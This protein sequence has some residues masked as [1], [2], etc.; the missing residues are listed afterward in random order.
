MR[1]IIT[2]LVVLS[3]AFGFAQNKEEILCQLIN[4]KTQEPVVFATVS[5]KDKSVGVIA[6]DNGNFRLPYKYK[7]NDD[8][9]VISCIGFNTIELKVVSLNDTLVNRIKLVPKIE[10]LEAITIIANKSKNRVKEDYIP[11]K[12][13]IKKAIY[14]MRLNF[15]TVPHSQ[16]GYYREYQILNKKYFN[17]NE[18]ILEDFDAGFQTNK[19]FYKDNQA[20]LYSFKKNDEFPKDSILTSAYDNYDSK[21]IENA[22]ITGF[23]GNELSILNIHNAIRHYEKK[24]FSFIDVFK[25]NFLYNHVFRLTNKLYLDDKPIY[26][27]K[28]YASE[29]VTGVKN[30]AEGVI[31]IAYDTFAIHKLEYYGYVLKQEKPFYSVTIEYKPK[32]NKMYLNYISF[33]NRFKVK[34]KNSFKVSAIEYD[35]TD[36]AFLINFNNEIDKET[37]DKKK[38]FRFTYFGDRLK[39]TKVEMINRTQLK[40]SLAQDFS[41]DDIANFKTMEGVEYKIKKVADL[42]GRRLNELSFLDVDQFREFFVQEVFANKQLPD[43]LNFVNKAMLLNESSININTVDKDKYWINSPL[44]TIKN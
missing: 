7:L 29:A 9:I 44:K 13:I 19:I 28:F 42:A 18:G 27:I 21:F 2:Y 22:T 32:G 11:A 35:T 15:P 25:D 8:T 31:Y 37:A 20:A 33:Y 26:E 39:I 43:D 30:R 17:L 5:V 10:S 38:Y 36:N 23:G 12:E 4:S 1:K 14:N 16:I 6:D 41:A 34:S 24:S 40:V 3:F